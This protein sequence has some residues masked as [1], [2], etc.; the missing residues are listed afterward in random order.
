MSLNDLRDPDSPWRAE[1]Q[2]T[3]EEQI[4]VQE[5]EAEE[6]A[7]EEEK[8]EIES[9]DSNSVDQPDNDTSRDQVTNSTDGENRTSFK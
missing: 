5:E 7:E 4:E 6:A 1:N 8:D 9:N 2:I 3:A